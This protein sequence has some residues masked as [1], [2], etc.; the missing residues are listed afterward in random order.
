MRS[1]LVGEHATVFSSFTWKCWTLLAEAVQD[2]QTS[3]SAFGAP[4]W[5]PYGSMA[6]GST[7]L[8]LQVLAQLLERDALTEHNNP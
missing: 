1:T 7:M 5:I 6:L 3:N 4:L 2:G 8:A